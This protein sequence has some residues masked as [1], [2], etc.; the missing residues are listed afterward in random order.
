MCQRQ[1]GSDPQRAALQDSIIAPI[2]QLY[3]IAE[4]EKLLEGTLCCQPESETPQGPP[5][6]EECYEQVKDAF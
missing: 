5:D 4:Q 1:E 2:L 3:R 6:P